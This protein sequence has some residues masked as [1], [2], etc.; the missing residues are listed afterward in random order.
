[1]DN[2]KLFLDH[3]IISM[4]DGSHT[5]NGKFED[6]ER[7]LR[8]LMAEEM[9]IKIQQEIME[10]ELISFGGKDEVYVRTVDAINV[11]KELKRGILNAKFN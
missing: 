10:Y 7:K 6:F 3:W 5:V 11:L 1:M 2:L 4:Q 9:V 8:E